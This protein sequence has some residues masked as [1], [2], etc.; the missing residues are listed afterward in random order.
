MGGRGAASGMSVDKHGNPKNKY[1][2]QYNTLLKVGNI[3]FV[4]KVS[5]QSETLMETMTKG[6][7]YVE[8][9]GKDLLRIVFFD[10]NNKR[11][12]VIERDKRTGEWFESVKEDGSV[13]VQQGLVHAWKCPYHNG[14]MCIE[15]I[16]RLSDAS[17]LNK[18]E[19]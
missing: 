14:R 9:G 7:V 16:R 18:F 1:G 2:T 12:H 13:D 5:R 8:V 19:L 6:R 11:N 3:K 15:I 10:E 17:F 4:S